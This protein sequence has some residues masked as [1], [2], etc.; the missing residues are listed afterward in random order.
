M[1]QIDLGVT[2]CWTVLIHFAGQVSG[3]A[4]ALI[5]LPY[6]TWTIMST[7]IVSSRPPRRPRVSSPQRHL[8]IR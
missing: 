3:A 1:I 4:S 2:G 7:S 8:D 6:L 5:P